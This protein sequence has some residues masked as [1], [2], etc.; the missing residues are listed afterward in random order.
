MQA[1]EP[2]VAEPP[3]T[4]P[5]ASA[6]EAQPAEASTPA[7]ETGPSQGAASGVIAAS[8]AAAAAAAAVRAPEPAEEEEAVSSQDTPSD[9]TTAGEAEVAGEP[10]EPAGEAGEVT[11]APAA[12]AAEPAPVASAEP[13]SVEAEPAPPAAAPAEPAEEPLPSSPETETAEAPGPA[14]GESTDPATAAAAAAA[15]AALAAASARAQPAPPA[16]QPAPEP[17]PE[18]APAPVA[19]EEPGDDLERIKGIDPDTA[20]AL[21]AHGVRRYTEIANWS[22]ADVQRVDAALG[23][24]GRITRENWIEQAQILA[25][26]GETAYTRERAQGGEA[27]TAP[28]PVADSASAGAAGPAGT[29]EAPSARPASTSAPGTPAP[30]P[31]LRSVKSEALTGGAAARAAGEGPRVLRSTVPDDL[32]RIKGIGILIEKKLNALGI[33]SYDQIAAWTREDIERISQVLDFKGRIERENWV[34]QARILSGGGRTE[35]SRR[36]DRGEV[37][38]TSDDES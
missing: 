35:F 18:A 17:A 19:A 29:A 23:L 5:E 9:T 32:K 21:R 6:A 33:T 34:E 38:P 22:N 4:E 16:E 25:R 31:S 13:V 12:A 10:S 30:A 27:G 26:G 15:T 28:A 1:P 20:A 7:P 37:A 2:A 8:V 24:Q 14:G 36:V 3:E 11:A